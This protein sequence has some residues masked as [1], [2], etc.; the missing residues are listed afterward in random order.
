MFAC[1][2]LTSGCPESSLIVYVERTRAKVHLPSLRGRIA[3]RVLPS[4]SI[5][6]LGDLHSVIRT[7]QSK[8]VS[9]CGMFSPPDHGLDFLGLASDHFPRSF[10]HC[11]LNHLCGSGPMEAQS[12]FI[13]PQPSSRTDQGTNYQANHQ[14][15]VVVAGTSSNQEESESQAALPLLK[16]V[17]LQLKPLLSEKLLVSVAAGVKLIDLQVC[18]IDQSVAY[19]LVRAYSTACYS[20]LLYEELRLGTPSF[21]IQRVMDA[22]HQVKSIRPEVLKVVPTLRHVLPSRSAH[23]FGF[24]WLMDKHI[25]S[26]DDII[27][28]EVQNGGFARVDIRL[29]PSLRILL[30]IFAKAIVSLADRVCFI[31]DRGFQN[32]VCSGFGI[33]CGSGGPAYIY[34][35]IEALADGGVAAGLPRE[36]ALGLASQTARLSHHVRLEFRKSEGYAIWSR[37]PRRGQLKDDVASPGG[38]TIAGIH[39]LEKGGFSWDLDECC[40]CRHQT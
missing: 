6:Q 33:F 24:D 3:L 21:S 7:F 8:L 20:E 14:G 38:I 39:E 30:A 32:I 13:W 37:A 11:I 23:T 35:A 22:N 2:Y 12:E 10:I 27:F 26:L 19:E 16:E 28:E 25:T 18:K 36:L 29:S 40:C 17:V 1:R 9:Q 15:S 4:G 31:L 34:L 5:L